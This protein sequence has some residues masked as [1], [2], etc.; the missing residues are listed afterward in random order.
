MK[1]FALY[2]AIELIKQFEGCRLKSYL[3]P[4]GVWTIG[5]GET[6]GVVEG[7]R[8]SQE[9]AD[10]MLKVRVYSF[11][12]Q[13]LA[14]CPTL[15]GE[16][17]AAATSLAYNIGKRAFYASTVRQRSKRREWQGAADAFLMWKRAG[18]RVLRGLLLRRQKERLVFLSHPTRK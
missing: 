17:L 16:R 6:H 13:C 18:G 14:D 1:P 9:H 10:N 12:M 5:W 11:M 2:L 8:W 4:A 15:E 7:M 3:C